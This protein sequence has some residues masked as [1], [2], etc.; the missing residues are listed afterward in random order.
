LNHG[1]NGATAVYVGLSDG[2]KFVSSPQPWSSFFCKSN[3]TCEVADVNGDGKADLIAFTLDPSDQ[4]FVGVSNGLTVTGPTAPQ[5]TFSPP[6]QW[7]T[8]FCRSGEVCRVADTNGDGSADIIAFNHGLDGAQAVYVAAAN[9]AGFA[10]F[11]PA[12]MASS[13]FCTSTEDCEVGDVDGDGRADVIAFTRSQ[14]PQAWVGLSI[15]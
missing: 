7:S 6:Q 2:T 14:T 10:G 15:P 8:F 13:F 9:S 3:E 4:T 11:T 1:L 12:H 5:G